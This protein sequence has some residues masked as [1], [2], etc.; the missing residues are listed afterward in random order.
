MSKT[1]EPNDDGADS[2]K[3]NRLITC[4]SGA[5]LDEKMSDVLGTISQSKSLHSECPISENK[6]S[7]NEPEQAPH[8]RDSTKDPP[9]LIYPEVLGAANGFFLFSSRQKRQRICESIG[10]SSC[11]EV[12]ECGIP[13]H[14]QTAPEAPSFLKVRAREFGCQPDAEDIETDAE[15]EE[16][17]TQLTMNS[18]LCPLSKVTPPLLLSNA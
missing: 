11:A 15:M 4:D 3:V 6:K 17:M 2:V 5:F 14:D 8:Q 12:E 9:I 7:K 10:S 1:I 16:D 18:I 13:Q